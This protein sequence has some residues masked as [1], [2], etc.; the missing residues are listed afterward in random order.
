MLIEP[1]GCLDELL[2]EEMIV[3][4]FEEEIFIDELQMIVYSALVEDKIEEE[5]ES[6]LISMESLKNMIYAD[7]FIEQGLAK[8]LTLLSDEVLESWI[9]SINSVASSILDDY[10]TEEYF[11][12]CSD[13]E[14]EFK[15]F[16]QE[17]EEDCYE[18]IR[19]DCIYDGLNEL[20]FSVMEEGSRA[21][22]LHSCT[23]GPNRSRNRIRCRS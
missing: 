17:V 8:E 2:I 14:S 21:R 20:V 4:L 22:Y 10:F 5:I 12:I 6:F 1:N 11:L 3:P 19:S 7:I 13:A 16:Y 23:S 15:E 9:A 18:Y